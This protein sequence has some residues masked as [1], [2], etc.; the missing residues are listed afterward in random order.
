[1]ADSAAEPAVEI[2]SEADAWD[3]PGL[4]VVTVVE[5]A[6]RAALADAYTGGAA[7]LSVLL[8]D[9][10]AIAELNR[11]W[12]G[13]DGP[14]NVLSF[15]ADD[16]PVAGRPLMLGDIVVA[17]GTLAREA[18]AGNIPFEHHLSHLIV[19]GVLHVLGYD[20]EDD[21][22]AEEMERRETAVLASLGV[23]DPYR[24]GETKRERMPS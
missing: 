17:Y 18:E 4:D 6:A 13:R 16:V 2:R 22:E 10:D 23:P 9:D 3:A 21:A 8:T 5:R 20:H 15:P 12:R 24:A 19:H 14:T 1:M 11:D 7:E